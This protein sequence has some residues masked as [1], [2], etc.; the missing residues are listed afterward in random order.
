MPRGG[1]FGGDLSGVAAQKFGQD[2]GAGVVL[3]GPPAE[4]RV[5]LD[6]LVQRPPGHRLVSGLHGQALPDECVSYFGG[7]VGSLHLSTG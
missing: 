4:R 5:T 7:C 6:H 3:T 1:C 2:R